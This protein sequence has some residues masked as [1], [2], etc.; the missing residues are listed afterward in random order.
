MG[1][2]H[3]PTSRREWV[4]FDFGWLT[5]R[6]EWRWLVKFLLFG[7][8]ALYELRTWTS[9]A[10]NIDYHYYKDLRISRHPACTH[11][12]ET[13][14]HRPEFA[15]QCESA[16]RATNADILHDNK[17]KCLWTEQPISLGKWE[18]LALLSV[19]GYIVLR[20]YMD[21]HRRI[22]ERRIQ[23]RESRRTLEFMHDRATNFPSFGWPEELPFL[24]HRDSGSRHRSN[25][26]VRIEPYY[27][28]N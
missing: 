8:L 2:P 16:L 28:N 18:S 1:R 3:R 20:L 21:Y 22:E 26:P 13:F 19:G 5:P 24:K 14:R 17:W 27:D 7:G 4:E 15:Q 25:S 23:S 6:L 9:C 10:N 12:A 11:D